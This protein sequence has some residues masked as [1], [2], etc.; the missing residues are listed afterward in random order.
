MRRSSL[1]PNRVRGGGGGGRPQE[2][3]RLDY[4]FVVKCKVRG[5]GR[6]VGSEYPI[7]VTL[8]VVPVNVIQPPTL[9]DEQLLL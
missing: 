3:D 4:S 7:M 2:A 1:F 6:M 5:R 8:A 9:R